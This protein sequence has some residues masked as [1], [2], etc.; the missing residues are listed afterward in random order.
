MQ[1]F[2]STKINLRLVN[3]K[4]SVLTY[5]KANQRLVASKSGV[6]NF[7]TVALGPLKGPQSTE[8][9]RGSHDGRNY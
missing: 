6:L 2:N 1:S 9:S 3:V 7:S 4:L 5:K 8:C